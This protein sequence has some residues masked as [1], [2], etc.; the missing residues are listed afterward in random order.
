MRRIFDIYVDGLDEP[1]RVISN[2]AGDE[3]LDARER[4]M[5][6]SWRNA[7]FKRN[8]GIPRRS[9]L[10]ASL[11]DALSSNLMDLHLLPDGDFLYA[12]CGR[13]VAAAFGSD[14]TG[15]RTSDLPSAIARVFLSV[16]RLGLK[17]PMPYSTRH[18]SPHDRV[19]FWHRLILPVAAEHSEDGRGYLVCS[20]PIGD[21]A[22]A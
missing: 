5:L 12:S 10:G 3:L 7:S 19:G 21:R 15:R 4:A 1:M 17:H 14:V 16:Y 2:P 20:L 6:K 9:E 8:G 22:R 13:A 18:R 11:I